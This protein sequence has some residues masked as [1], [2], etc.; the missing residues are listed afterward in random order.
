MLLGK[1]L[2]RV[3]EFQDLYQRPEIKAW[4]DVA[5]RFA[6]VLVEVIEFLRS[7]LP[8]YP[9]LLVPDLLAGSSRVYIDGLSDQRFPIEARGPAGASQVRSPARPYWLRHLS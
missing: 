4:F 1:R 2:G 3:P 8:G 7:R 5:Q 9:R 6:F